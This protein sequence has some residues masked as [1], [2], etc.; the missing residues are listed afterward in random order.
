M[1]VEELK[2]FI[3]A[4]EEMRRFQVLYFKNRLASD[5]QR[6]KAWE[7]EVDKIIAKYHAAENGVPVVSKERL[8]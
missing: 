7:R 5:L 3:Y 8:L 4:V 1:N 2:R 6:A